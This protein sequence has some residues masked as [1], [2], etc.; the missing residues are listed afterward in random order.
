M[1]IYTQKMKVTRANSSVGPVIIV[2]TP[3]VSRIAQVY[4][5]EGDQGMVV[6]WGWVTS[7]FSPSTEPKSE[8]VPTKGGCPTIEDLEQ[9][10]AGRRF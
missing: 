1:S 6:F 3:G 4:Q 2:H 7:G 8:R 9:L 10:L 5:Q